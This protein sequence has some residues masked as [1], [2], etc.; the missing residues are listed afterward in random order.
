MAH[1]YNL[2]VN[3]FVGQMARSGGLPS[4]T[5]G[6]L[7]I[8]KFHMP[9]RKHLD[10]FEDLQMKQRPYEVGHRTEAAARCG[11]EKYSTDLAARVL[12]CVRGTA[13]RCVSVAFSLK[14]D[15]RPDQLR[16]LKRIVK[17]MKDK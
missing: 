1:I 15:R 11:V 2:Q 13:E 17:R 3:T 4:G 12:R 10:D 6:S 7:Q 14:R 8:L 16:W 5:Q 9:I